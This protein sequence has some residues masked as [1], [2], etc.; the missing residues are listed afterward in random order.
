MGTYVVAAALT[1]EARMLWRAA[2][3]KLR[4]WGAAIQLTAL[5]TITLHHNTLASCRLQDSSPHERTV[6]QTAV[7][8]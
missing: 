1:F 6:A 3:K 4:A 8:M 2:E 7:M 5:N